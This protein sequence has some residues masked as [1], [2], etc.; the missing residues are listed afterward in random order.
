MLTIFLIAV[1]P[2]AQA[3]VAR[4]Y[5]FNINTQVTPYIRILLESNRAF[6]VKGLGGR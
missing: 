3:G 1:G 6:H 4:T 5:I 2:L